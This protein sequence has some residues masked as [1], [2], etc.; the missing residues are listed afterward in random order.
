MCGHQ[1][2]GFLFFLH[3]PQR[4]QIWPVVERVAKNLHSSMSTVTLLKYH[5]VSFR[6]TGINNKAKTIL[7]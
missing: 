5:S 6:T 7:E 2:L 4:L 1:V 3:E